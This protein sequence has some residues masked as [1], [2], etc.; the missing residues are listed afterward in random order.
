MDDNIFYA[1]VQSEPLP[2]DLGEIV[3]RPL[4][5]ECFCGL[6]ATASLFLLFFFMCITCFRFVVSCLVVSILVPVIDWKVFGLV[7]EP[8]R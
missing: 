5:F 6:F 2:V 3:W 8:G 4:V 1:I 7:S